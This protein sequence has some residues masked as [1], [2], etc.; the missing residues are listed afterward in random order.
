MPGERELQRKWVT[1]PEPKT[2]QEAQVWYGGLKNDASLPAEQRRPIR[3]PPATKAAQR[4]FDEADKLL[5]REL[6]AEVASDRMRTTTFANHVGILKTHLRPEFGGRTLAEAAVSAVQE[7]RLQL[8]TGKLRSC[9]QRAVL[10]AL[11]MVLGG[12]VESEWI[13]SNPVWRLKEA[14]RRRGNRVK[15]DALKPI[16]LARTEMLLL[17]KVTRTREARVRLPIMLMAN[18][19]MRRGEAYGLQRRDF[20]A[21]AGTLAIRRMVSWESF[22]PSMTRL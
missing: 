17:E 19:G 20:D 7:F 14:G 6:D 13:A 3:P 8:M 15:S 9:T 22:E 21:E 10:G 16:A 4:T 2:R 18:V 12:A 5:L 1:S 11:G